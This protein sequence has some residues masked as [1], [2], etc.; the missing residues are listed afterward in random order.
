MNNIQN[1]QKRKTNLIEDYISVHNKNF[2]GSTTQTSSRNITGF[3]KRSST[4]YIVSQIVFSNNLQTN[5]FIKVQSL[6]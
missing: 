6:A 2:G 1:E 3:A 4:I 5:K